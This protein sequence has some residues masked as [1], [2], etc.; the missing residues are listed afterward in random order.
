[1]ISR[2]TYQQAAALLKAGKLLA[3][4]TETVYG[5]GVDARNPDAIKKLFAAKQRA[6]THPL[7]LLIGDAAELTQWADAIP[8]LAWVLAEKYWP[9]PLT[10][11]LPRAAGVSDLLTGG[12][13]T[14]GLRVPSHPVVLNLLKTFGSA[15]ANSSANLSGQPSLT[16]AAQVN[17]SLGKQ[18]DMLLAEDAGC[19]D[20][21]ST[22]LDLTQ[23]RPKLLRAGP[24]NVEPYL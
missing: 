15:I 23:T 1:M 24:I 9:G 13:P 8:P 22:V 4:P 16:T 6:A 7:A 2:E 5:L 17:A 3:F 18:I 14:I 19:G 10:L 20:L 12:H 11:V 21:A